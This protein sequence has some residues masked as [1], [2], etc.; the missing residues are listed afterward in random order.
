MNTVQAVQQLTRVLREL[1]K[2][3]RLVRTTL[4]MESNIGAV[5]A[6]VCPEEFEDGEK[7]SEVDQRA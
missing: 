4:Q 1:V 3:I 2:E 5:L 7:E 6:A